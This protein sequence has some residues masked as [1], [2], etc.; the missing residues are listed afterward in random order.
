MRR[1]EAG[2]INTTFY[3]TTLS[4]QCSSLGKRAQ[5]PGDNDGPCR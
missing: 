3:A 1:D 4:K 5:F 2:T